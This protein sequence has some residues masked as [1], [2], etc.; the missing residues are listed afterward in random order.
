MAS[1]LAAFGF[2]QFA[3]FLPAT[4]PPQQGQIPASH[5]VPFGARFDIEIISAPH[6]I[7]A[8]RSFD[9]NS[10]GIYEDGPPTTYVH[11]LISQRTL[12]LGQNFER[13]GDRVDGW[14]EMETFLEWQR[15]NLGKAQYGYACNGDY[16]LVDYGKVTDGVPVS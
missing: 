7:S 11:F 14:C 13:C 4:G 9:P 2:T 5:Y 3:T 8:N 12:P 10:E 6:P 16:E 15:G 1:V